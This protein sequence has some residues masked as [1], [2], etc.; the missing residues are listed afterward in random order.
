MKIEILQE[1]L[2]KV[3]AK[4]ARVIAVRPQLAVLANVLVEVLRDGIKLSATDLELG[5][6]IKVRAKTEGEGSITVPAKTLLEFVSSLNPGKV[7]I[8]LDRET[9]SVEAGKYRGKFQTIP[10]EEFPKLPEFD[11]SQIVAKLGIKELAQAVETVAYAAAKDSLRPVLT[12]IL[13]EVEKKKVKLVATDGFRLATKEVKADTQVEQKTTLLIPVRT[14]MEVAKMSEEGEVTIA[15]AKKTNQVLFQI[16]EAKIVTQ[17]IDG[18]F[19]DYARIVP[20]EFGSEVTINREELLAAVKTAH[21]FARDNSNMM[22]WKLEESMLTVRAE[23]PERGETEVT[24]E[25]ETEGEGGE[26]VFNAKFVM[27]CLTASNSEQIK[28]AMKGK[29]DPCA[30]LE[31]GNKD[32]LYVVMPINA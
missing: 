26:V 9:L 7:T 14:M 19:P 4:V 8:A 3:L 23:T 27:D 32:F 13:I 20:K 1:E 10:A 25:V 21:I 16:D 28:F 6:A 18:N 12:G 30:F 5:V 17:L 15:Y 2:V 31:E 11:G 24:L 29:L 22:R